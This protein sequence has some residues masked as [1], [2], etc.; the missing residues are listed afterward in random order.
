MHG[1]KIYRVLG[2]Q[3]VKRRRE[4]G[5][6]IVKIGTRCQGVQCV[7]VCMLLGVQVVKKCRV[8][9]GVGCWGCRVS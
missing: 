2:V 3:S 9:R 1:V 4:S 6:Q 7:N 5:V 8:Y